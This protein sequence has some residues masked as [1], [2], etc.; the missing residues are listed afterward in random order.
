MSIPPFVRMLSLFDGPEL[1]KEKWFPRAGRPGSFKPT[2]KTPS[3]AKATRSTATLLIGSVPVL[4]FLFFSPLSY[5]LLLGKLCVKAGD[6]F[7]ENS[8]SSDCSSLKRMMYS[9]PLVRPD[10]PGFTARWLPQYYDHF[11]AYKLI[12]GR[13]SHR[14]LASR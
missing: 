5:R 11:C 6:N 2:L 8:L 14:T 10:I 7:R 9:S 4:P 12:F 1:F 13:G 3:S